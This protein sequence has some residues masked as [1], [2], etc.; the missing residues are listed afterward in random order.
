VLGLAVL[1]ERDLKDPFLGQPRFRTLLENALA[2]LQDERDLRGF[3]AKKG[4]IH[5]TA[6]TADLL[7]ELAE[8]RYFTNQD[9]AR[10]LAAIEQRLATA[11]EIFNHGEQ[12]RLAS[13]AATIV[14]RH[15]FDRA[16]WHSWVAGI[17]KADQAVFNE[18]PPSL[19]A[20]QRF[21]NDS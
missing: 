18:S 8:S 6:H 14:S 5:A 3:D 12:D 17:D 21:E 4:W 1:A 20:E 13:V 2:Y 16:L 10:V 15:D 7:A 9:Q 11:N 19:Q